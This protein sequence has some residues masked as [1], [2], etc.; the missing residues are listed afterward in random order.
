LVSRPQFFK[1]SRPSKAKTK[2]KTSKKGL[3]TGLKDY[4]TVSD[5]EDD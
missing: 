3:K 1:T 4:V 5:D 2:I